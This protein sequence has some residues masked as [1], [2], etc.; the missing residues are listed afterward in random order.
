MDISFSPPSLSK[1]LVRK[2]SQALNT[3]FKMTLSIEVF[4]LPFFLWKWFFFSPHRNYIL[5]ENSGSYSRKISKRKFRACSQNDQYSSLQG[6]VA[7]DEGATFATCH[8]K[9]RWWPSAAALMLL[10]AMERNLQPL[11]P[12][13]TAEWSP[14]LL[15]QP[16]NYKAQTQTHLPCAKQVH[17]LS[18]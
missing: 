13:V 11:Q 7:R 18:F 9:L 14:L 15:P 6:L 5:T 4:P 3:L 10:A 8:P 2:V 1:N 17:L 16:V 12:T